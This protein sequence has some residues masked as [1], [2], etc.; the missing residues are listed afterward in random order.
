MAAT[1]RAIN[2]RLACRLVRKSARLMRSLGAAGGLGAVKTNVAGAVAFR[3]SATGGTSGCV[4]RCIEAKT[5]L[6]LCFADLQPY[7]LVNSSGR[8]NRPGPWFRNH[9]RLNYN[10]YRWLWSG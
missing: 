3:H 9:Y 8:R 10:G 5:A 7:G 4:A 2:K 1:A 6:R